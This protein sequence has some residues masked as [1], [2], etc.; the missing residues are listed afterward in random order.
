MPLEPCAVELVEL[1][2][3]FEAHQRLCAFAVLRGDG[4]RVDSAG[5]QL[6]PQLRSSAPDQLRDG[7]AVCAEDLG[8]L[9]VR[10]ALELAQGKHLAIAERQAG[11][12]GADLVL[13]GFE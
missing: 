3:L 2:V 9:V 8:D 11:V 7:V 1:P 10:T 5:S 4:N 6:L 13:R 12:G